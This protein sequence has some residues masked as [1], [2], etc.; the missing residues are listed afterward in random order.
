MIDGGLAA[1][2]HLP[3]PAQ[4]ARRTSPAAASMRH[5]LEELPAGVDPCGEN[6]EFHTFAC[7]GPMFRQPIAVETGEIVT[8]DG[9]IFCDLL[10]VPESREAPGHAA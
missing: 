2:H 9:F 8:R 4:A 1:L 7:A 10:P 3:R 6:G 5:L